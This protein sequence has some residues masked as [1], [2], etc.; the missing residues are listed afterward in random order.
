[1]FD[2]YCLILV[3]PRHMWMASIKHE[4]DNLWYIKKNTEYRYCAKFKAEFRMHRLEALRCLDGGK[5]FK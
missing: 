1:V 3:V 2:G 4:Q 5:W